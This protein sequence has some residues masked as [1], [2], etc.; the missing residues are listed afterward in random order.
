MRR[1]NRNDVGTL[2]VGRKAISLNH[3]PDRPAPGS[4]IALQGNHPW[5]GAEAIVTEY[6][7]LFHS[8]AQV[9]KAELV[10]VLPGHPV[11]V[12]G[13]DDFKV[14]RGPGER[15]E[16]EVDEWIGG[17]ISGEVQREDRNEP[18]VEG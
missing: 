10:T 15:L 14:L 18:D 17:C 7:T 11:T 5:K 2:R 8:G 6:V 12:D 16:S 4:R 13:T 1:K 9:M 3:P